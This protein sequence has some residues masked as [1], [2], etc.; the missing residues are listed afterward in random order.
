MFEILYSLEKE[1]TQKTS[2]GPAIGVEPCIRLVY[3]F[4]WECGCCIVIG[5]CSAA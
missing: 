5:G 1:L 3:G 4:I 2:L